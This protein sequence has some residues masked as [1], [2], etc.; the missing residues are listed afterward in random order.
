MIKILHVLKDFKNGIQIPIYKGGG[1]DAKLW[2]NHR[3]IK[4]LPV[5]S[6]FFE[7]LVMGHAET[8]FEQAVDPH[9]GAALSGCSSL[10]STIF[11]RETMSYVL[12]GSSDAYVV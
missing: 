11:V 9:Q 2:E 6:K 3:G 12:E 1:K 7:L 4:L 8:F 10:H 5:L